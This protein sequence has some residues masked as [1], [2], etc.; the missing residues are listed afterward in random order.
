MSIRLYR[1]YITKVLF[2]IIESLYILICEIWSN[3]GNIIA[4][5]LCYVPIRRNR[6]GNIGA[7]FKGTQSALLRYLFPMLPMFPF[8]YIRSAYRVP[9]VPDVTRG[10]DGAYG[11][12]APSG[13]WY[14]RAIL[15][16]LAFAF[17]TFCESNAKILSTSA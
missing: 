14:A 2:V 6:K 16:K 13:T 4:A 9:S 1:I 10:A 12:F 7:T 17:I 5:S 11:A 8:L 15:I 3:T